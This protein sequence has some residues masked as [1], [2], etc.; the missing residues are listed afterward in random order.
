MTK[1]KRFL[2]TIIFSAVNFAMFILGILLKADLTAL[3]TGLSLINS[4]LYAYIIGQ[5]I[6]KSD[7]EQQ[8]NN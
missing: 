4:P 2:L 5:S 8:Q 1:S 3:G 7:S 6:R